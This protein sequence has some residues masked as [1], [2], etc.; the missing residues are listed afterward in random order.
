MGGYNSLYAQQTQK[1]TPEQLDMQA[2]NN[3]LML[4]MSDKLREVAGQGL[5]KARIRKDR[6]FGQRGANT[7]GFNIAEHDNFKY[8]PQ[9]LR[10]LEEQAEYLIKKGKQNQ[11]LQDISLTAG[12][13]IL[14]KDSDRNNAVINALTLVNHYLDIAEKGGKKGQEAQQKAFDVFESLA[15][16][17]TSI[18]QLLRQY[19]Q[20]KSSTPRGVL[21]LVEKQMHDA[22][23]K[24]SDSSKN[25]LITLTD[26]WQQAIN[27]EIE[28]EE[29]FLANPSK[30]TL[31]A[32]QKAK[33]NTIISKRN[34][35]K[36]AA[37]S[38]PKDIWTM[39]GTMLKGGLLT[40][41]SQVMNIV[42]NLSM[43]P[44][45]VPTN[46][47]A[48]MLDS[49]FEKI[50]KTDIGRTN[51]VL[52]PYTRGRIA[53]PGVKSGIRKAGEWFMHGTPS[54]EL[55]KL[56]LT[57]SLKP[58]TAFMQA[59]KNEDL[60][61]DENG[62]VK[63]SDRWIK[64]FAIEGVFGQIP[65]TMLRLLPFGD[66]PFSDAVY[67]QT[68]HEQAVIK[69]LK[70]GTK[71]YM[72][73]MQK[74]DSKTQELASKKAKET[75]FQEDLLISD[76]MNLIKT[77]VGEGAITGSP[78]EQNTRRA[79]R[80]FLLEA[81]MPYVKTPMNI[82]WQ[83]TQYAVP[84]LAFMN[85][86]FSGAQTKHFLDKSRNTENA[87]LKEKYLLRA[88][89]AK[90]TSM[91]GIGKGI[92][93]LA[94][95]ALFRVLYNLG[96][97][98]GSE[99]DPKLRQLQL[100]GSI[101]ANSFN[102]SAY[103]RWVAGGFDSSQLY[104][105]QKGDITFE[106]TRLTGIGMTWTVQA[107]MIA[108]DRKQ[109][110]IVGGIKE[111]KGGPGQEEIIPDIKVAT[112]KI[113]LFQ[114]FLLSASYGLDQSFLVGIANA[115]NALM[116][117]DRNW[118]TFMRNWQ[119]ATSA[120][121]MPNLL[122]QIHKFGSPHE[123][124]TRNRYMDKYGRKKGVWGI[125]GEV[126][127]ER[128]FWMDSEGKPIKYDSFGNKV[129]QT[130]EGHNR[131]L[132]TLLNP[133]KL[134]QYDA[135]LAAEFIYKLYRA[136]SRDEVVPP[137]LERPRVNES[138]KKL[139]KNYKDIPESFLGESN[140][141]KPGSDLTFNQEQYEK[142]QELAGKYQGEMINKVVESLLSSTNLSLDEIISQD[143]F[144]ITE[145][146]AK[147]FQKIYREAREMAKNEILMS[148]WTG[149]EELK[150][151]ITNENQQKRANTLKL[152]GLDKYLTSEVFREREIQKSRLP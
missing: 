3:F 96:I 10:E 82:I 138:W 14:K 146:V 26:K 101:G 92:V 68:L 75:V 99:D 83:G 52:N 40:P 65:E 57:S 56:D 74:P 129:P 61:L 17:G 59:I 76:L 46:Y 2:K 4:P 123:I 38:I 6:Q 58:W 15:V 27:N 112:E 134:K 124:S 121:F 12:K 43:T 93:G 86:M 88:A 9:S 1:L 80:F 28:I 54:E 131:L 22:N 145:P 77:K 60:P 149:N 122:A 8:T 120:P 140:I 78:I 49:V 72:V 126:F 81:N 151:R 139:I 142:Y 42:G 41:A 32:L 136:D 31:E 130:P 113:D 45:R 11:I 102:L 25:K 5:P 20:L 152:I 114:Q 90:R 33:R 48:G 109:R 115:T 117:P 84:T 34:F 44:L 16:T 95:G 51:V 50:F 73:F 63:F 103:K 144:P 87:A 35:D 94:L 66:K 13:Q 64:K 53:W 91:E 116:D 143:K 79:L 69:G 97:V 39:F 7:W 19:G 108:E 118:P 29:K 24:L 110:R 21:Y 70:E 36:Q 119:R 18:G 37:K 100:D 133:L 150:N 47:I 67:Y 128:A 148:L 85:A 125:A 30:K 132:Y 107:D 71:A 106:Y 105:P 147:A 111:I 104:I 127:W 62:E 89:S 23:R 98:S 135:D 55:A 137:L 141:L